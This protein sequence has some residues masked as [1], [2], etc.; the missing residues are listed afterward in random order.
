MEEITWLEFLGSFTPGDLINT[1]IVLVIIHMIIY[2]I[3]HY[4]MDWWENRKYY[5]T[6]AR[7]YVSNHSWEMNMDD[8]ETLTFIEKSYSYYKK[9]PEEFMVAEKEY[10]NHLKSDYEQEEKLKRILIRKRV[11]LYDYED[12]LC[13]IYAPTAER[14]YSKRWEATDL[15][16]EH[17][18]GRIEKIMN[19]SKEDALR[20]FDLLVENKVLEKSWRDDDK[21]SLCRMLDSE[22]SPRDEWKVVTDIDIDLSKWMVAHGY[23]IENN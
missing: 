13:E 6:I 1:F 22:R 11:F 12:M 14:R 4:V 10:K 23:Y 20:I 8:S 9:H 3:R 21:Y 5:Q 7:H 17:I 16:K 2:S 18:I 19:T 15:E